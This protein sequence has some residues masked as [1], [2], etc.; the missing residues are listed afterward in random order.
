MA[1]RPKP[2]TSFSARLVAARKEISRG[3]LARR[4]GVPQSTLGNWELGAAV[5]PLDVLCRIAETL[6]VSL[7][8][9]IA[10]RT[11]DTPNIGHGSTH[12]SATRPLPTVDED[13]VARLAEGVSSAYADVGRPI[14]PGMLGRIVAKLYNEIATVVDSPDEFSGAMKMRLAQFR[15][16]LDTQPVPAC[17]G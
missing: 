10:G 13:H 4:L 8:W 6:D 1:R 12:G 3:D 15:K 9:L 14:A 7:D 17:S 11:G 2:R 5:P 16:E